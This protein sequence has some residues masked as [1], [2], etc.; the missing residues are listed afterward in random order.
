MTT[1]A[2]LAHHLQAINKSIDAIISN[3]TEESVLFTQSGPIIGLV[4]I[5]AFF[6][7]FISDAPPTLIPALSVIMVHGFTM[8]REQACRRFLPALDQP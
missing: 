6:E 5:R 1:E 4:G 7:R 3:Y 2:T 8:V